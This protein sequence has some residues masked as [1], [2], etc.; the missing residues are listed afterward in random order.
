M[1]KVYD[2]LIIIDLYQRIFMLY[3]ESHCTLAAAESSPLTLNSEQRELSRDFCAPSKNKSSIMK[4]DYFLC[5]NSYIQLNEYETAPYFIQFSQNLTFVDFCVFPPSLPELNL[6][7][8]CSEV[9]ILSWAQVNLGQN[10]DI[11][12]QSNAKFWLNWIKYGAVS[13][14]LSC[15]LVLLYT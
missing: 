7:L 12:K 9:L 15:I 5:W 13:Y 1:K 10:T 14:S 4:P 3:F 11:N 8:F 6:K 2:D